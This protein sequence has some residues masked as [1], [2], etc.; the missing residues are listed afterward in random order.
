MKTAE[1]LDVAEQ[2]KEDIIKIVKADKSP[3][4]FI[5]DILGRYLDLREI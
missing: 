2:V 1:T 5:K 3:G 4:M